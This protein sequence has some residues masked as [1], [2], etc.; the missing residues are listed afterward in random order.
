MKSRLTMVIVLTFLSVISFQSEAR[1]K[2]KNLVNNDSNGRIYL[3]PPAPETTPNSPLLSI[4]WKTADT[5][6]LKWTDRSKVE[7]GF[8][9]EQLG[10][11]GLWEVID[12]FAAKNGSYMSQTYEITDLYPDTEY[13]HRLVAYNDLGE[14]EPVRVQ[15]ACANTATEGSCSGDKIE[16]VLALANDA[17]SAETINCDLNL[18]PGQVITKRLVFYGAEASGVVVDLNG[19]TLN[20]GKGTYNYGKDM[21]EIR[22]RETI[23]RNTEG[24]ISTYARPQNITIKNGNIIGAVRIWGMAKNGQ[25]DPEYETRDVYRCSTTG[26]CS[27]V[28]KKFEIPFSNQFKKSSRLAGHPERARANAPT[29]I[30]L[31]NLTITGLGRNPLYFAPGVTNS[32][33]INSELKGKSNAVGIYL[34][35]ESAENTIKNNYIHISTKNNW[36]EKWDRP[37]I[38][39]DGSSKNRILNNRFSNLSHGGIYLYRNC[40]EGGVIRH[41]T[42]SY[43]EIINNIFYYNK[44]DGDNPAVYLGSHDRGGWFQDT[45]GFCEDDAGYPFGS[46]ASDRDYARYNVVMQNQIYKNSINHMIRTKNTSVNS[47]NYIDYNLTVTEETVDNEQPAGCYVKM[48]NRG[49]IFHDESF[50]INS[51][52]CNGI[53]YTCDNGELKNE[54]VV[55][56]SPRCAF[57]QVKRLGFSKILKN[58]KR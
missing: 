22:S 15:E 25:G 43:N 27:W 11:D 57:P 28:E 51:S 50:E 42:P 16:Q 2:I 32:K 38:A 10:D 35:A 8:R 44:Y 48:G 29:N 36:F 40:G 52:Q 26:V 17:K 24:A 55:D 45:F 23:V 56:P 30:I 5:I 41:A 18:E 39:I 21:L 54:P 9:L 4:Y 12:T 31:D 6:M 7:D 19:A 20:G 49:F 37:L 14:S 53:R 34:G 1:V 33:L 46:S 13:C 47:P 58:Y 3:P